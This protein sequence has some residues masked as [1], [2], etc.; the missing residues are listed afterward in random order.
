MTHP[1]LTA[2]QAEAL[3]AFA[4]SHGFG[5]DWREK[6]GDCWQKASYPAGAVKP[7]ALQQVRNQYGPTWLHDTYAPGWTPELPAWGPHITNGETSKLP[8]GVTRWSNASPPPGIGDVVRVRINA[9]GPATVTGYFV[10]SGFLG[11]I[12][13]PHSPPEFYTKQNGGAVPG[14]SFGAEIDIGAAQ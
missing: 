3:V 7:H 5:P 14:H 8:E 10:E 6:L 11:V 13:K 4:A 12:V 9:I 1:A 2:D